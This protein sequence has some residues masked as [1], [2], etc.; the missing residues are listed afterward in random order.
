MNSHVFDRTYALGIGRF[1]NYYIDHNG[2][3]VADNIDVSAMKLT[4]L[5]GLLPREQIKIFGNFNC[6]RNNLFNFKWFP[7]SLEVLGNFDC[8]QNGLR[9]LSGLPENF[10]VRGN[11]DCS[12]NN[13]RAI[14]GLPQKFEIDGTFYCYKNT[15]GSTGIL[16]AFP[17]RLLDGRTLRRH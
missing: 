6:S 14:C 8:S 13:L 16:S 10:I 15:I 4:T 11:F 2:T 12:H 1:F 9:D 3:F 7:K 5:Y 17:Q